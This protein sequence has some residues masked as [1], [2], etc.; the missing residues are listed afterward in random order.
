MRRFGLVLAALLLS[1]GVPVHAQ[2]GVERWSI[3]TG[4]DSQAP[5]ISLSTY[6]STTIYNMLS[7]A[8][9]ASLPANSR[10]APREL[11]QYRVSGTLTKYKRETDSDYHIVIQDSSG[12]TMIVEI[13]S[14]N[15]VGGG[16]PFGSGV[17][18]ARA[19][20]D[21]RLTATT[22][23][24][25]TSIPITIKGIGFWDF[26][27]GQTGVAPNGIEVHPVLDITFNSAKTGD[28]DISVPE[29][30]LPADMVEDDDGGRVQVYRGGD[31][32]GEI[33]FHGGPVIE[34]PRLRIVFAG[35]R[36]T[37]ADKRA[38]TDV[39]RNINS[40]PQFDSLER[41]GVTNWGMQ[42][43]GRHPL[44]RNLQAGGVAPEMNDLDVQ[45]LLA[46]AV[47]EGRIQHVSPDVLT[48]VVL[49]RD[50][51]LA[52]GRTRD[53]LSYHSQFHPSEVAMPY[54]VVRG[55]LAPEDFRAS[56]AASVFRA[57]VNPAGD[58]WF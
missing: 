23:F 56:L 57:L 25:T 50:T 19:Q 18:H 39:V 46:S 33:L 1:H 48:I 17:S 14:P 55:G 53:W 45:R 8:H 27:H 35:D 26:L 9:P 30:Q 6:V 15:C 12:R 13:P 24:K 43:E 2:C 49:D 41:Y 29:A 47:D 11:T 38:V 51:S 16:S 54:V 3:K 34:H 21:A 42:L 52:V 58:G 31:A 32:A 20:F 28:E 10:I 22:S 4:T 7:S 40:D 37:D 5:S 36:W 44:P